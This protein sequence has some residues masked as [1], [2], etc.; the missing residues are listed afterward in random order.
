MKSAYLV[1]GVPGN[2][3]KE[4]IEEAFNKARAYYSASKPAADPRAGEKFLEVRN[5]YYVLRD[6]GSRAAHDRKLNGMR[7]QPAVAAPSARTARAVRQEPQAAWFTHPLPVLATVVALVFAVG[8]YIKAQRE[9][10]RKEQAAQE[11][12]LKQL[13]A[14][15]AK[16]EE[17]CL[18]KEVADRVRESL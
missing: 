4:D 17:I 8:F 1:L 12:Q 7:S 16:K 6:D 2:A 9:A 13:A 15:E 5:A 11:L 18:A 10:A 14:E 3:S